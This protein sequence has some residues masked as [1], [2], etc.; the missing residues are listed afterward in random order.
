MKI[1]APFRVSHVY[2][3]ILHAPPATVFRLLC[4]VRE[5]EWLSDW[6][7]D[8]VVSDSGFAEPDCMFVTSDDGKQ[9]IWVIT[10]HDPEALEIRMLKTTPGELVT[11]IEIRCMPAEKKETRCRIRYTFTA[12]SKTGKEI[13]AG[14]DAEW[15]RNFMNRWEAAMNR[16]LE[17]ESEDAP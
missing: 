16:Y 9:S 3:Q 10:R 12:L 5:T 4:P 13:V 14:R 2:D 1:E 17:T 15:Y 7:P 6:D 11:Q 8:L